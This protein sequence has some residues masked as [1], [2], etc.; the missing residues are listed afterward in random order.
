M[1]F[2]RVEITTSISWSDEDIVEQLLAHFVSLATLW[3]SRFYLR[4]ITIPQLMPRNSRLYTYCSCEHV[5]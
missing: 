3:L 2:S 1:L 4:G 5:Q